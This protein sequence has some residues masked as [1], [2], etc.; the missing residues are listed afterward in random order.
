MLP[1]A[2][3]AYIE[4]RSIRGPWELDLEAVSLLPGAIV[5]PSLAE[6]AL[7]PNTINSLIADHTLA[8]SG[9]AVVFVVN[10]RFD[11]N[12]DEKEDN[13]QTLDYLFECRTRLPFPVGIIDAAS[14]GFELPSKDGGVGFARKLGHDLLLP[15]FNYTDSDPLIVSLDADTVV[16]PGYS[17]ALVEH[18]NKSSEGGAVIPFKH[19]PAMTDTENRAIERYELFIRCYV[20]GLQYA[21]SPYAFH[22]VGS[23]MACQV[24]AYIKCGG[25]NRRRAGEDFYFLQS[26]A[27]TSG[28][29]QVKGT[30]VFPSP[31]RSC[32]VP[33][34]TGRA[35]GQLLDQIPGSLLFY[36]REYYCILKSWLQIAMDCCDSRCKMLPEKGADNSKLLGDFLSEQGFGKAWSGFLVQH[37]TSDRL[38]AAFHCWF[39][40]FRTLKLFHYLDERGLTRGEA[41]LLLPK[42]PEA[43]GSSTLSLTERLDF[44]RHIQC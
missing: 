4:K 28:I 13:Q 10:N 2:V 19:L 25:M 32:R 42:F 43:F 9:L 37:T 39:D 17:A 15:F 35:V 26:L 18:F 40:A 11:A 44:L 24:S 1:E 3:S 20:A 31:R 16:S 41:E 8:D 22:T 12:P 21:C 14:L 30:T 7:L 23:A 29:A 5:I 33:F 27:K 38:K 6:S 34:G 36:P